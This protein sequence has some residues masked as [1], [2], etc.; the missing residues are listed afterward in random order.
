MNNANNPPEDDYQELVQL[1]TRYES[2]KSNKQFYLDAEQILEIAE[3]YELHD[4]PDEAYEVLTYGLSWHPDHT[5]ILVTLAYSY[6]DK[7]KPEE[8]KRIAILIEDE[9]SVE[10]KMLRAELLLAENQVLEAEAILDTLEDEADANLCL[11]VASLYIQAD[12][13]SHGLLWLQKAALFAPEDE[14]LIWTIAECCHNIGKNEEAIHYFNILIDQQP[15][16]ADSWAGLAKVYFTQELYDKA[17][18]ACDF[19]LVADA[20][21]Y[22]AHL[23]KAHSL[24]QLGNYEESIKEY[25]YVLA[26]GDYFSEYVYA[27]IGACYCEMQEW[28]QACAYYKKALQGASELDESKKIEVYINLAT[29]LY[30]IGRFDKAHELCDTMETLFPD[31]FDSYLL[32]GRIYSEEENKEKAGECW[33]KVLNKSTND[34]SVLTQIGEYCLDMGD[35]ARAKT[36]LERAISM[37][38]NGMII[39]MYL[40][41]TYVRLKDWKSLLKIHQQLNIPTGDKLET[42][43]REYFGEDESLS[44]EVL[45]TIGKFEQ[46]VKKK[47]KP[48]I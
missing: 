10:A 21:F 34:V 32:N 14:D 12:H 13:F 24:Y 6:I 27:Y 41:L 18:E 33:D 48:S 37:N 30:R 4:K 31:F 40:I 25:R 11:N 17:V 19:A 28:E 8:A 42:F 45:E 36:A 35:L 38:P 9:Y 43:I 5:G 1:I 16:S 23:F 39:K 29:C 22:D 3:W 2:M 44:S 20:G 7:G 47:N 46:K 15:Y 26:Q